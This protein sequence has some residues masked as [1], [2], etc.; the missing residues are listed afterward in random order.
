[1]TP[2]AKSQRGLFVTLEGIE[3]CGKSTQ[4]R[5]AAARLK[6][7]G[8]RVVLTAEPGGT[9]LGKTLRA[10]LLKPG[11]RVAPLTEW[12]LFEADRAQHVDRMIRPA[13]AKGAVVICDRYSDSTRAYQGIGRGLGLAAV[14]AVDRV[15]TAGLKPDL[16]FLLDL[17]VGEGLARARKRGKLTRLD[18]ERTKFHQKIRDAFLVLATQEPARIKVIDGR[19]GKAEA[20]EVIWRHLHAALARRGTR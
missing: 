8:H 11:A 14:D 4:A 13:L 16:T 3:G 15:A 2:P 18:R 1:M 7:T 5:L 19:L 9:P 10:A 12:L 17:P 6:A 20:A